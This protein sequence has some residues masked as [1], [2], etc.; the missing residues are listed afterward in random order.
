MKVGR[1]SFPGGKATG[2]PIKL[3]DI[4][5]VADTP[6]FGPGEDVAADYINSQLGGINGHPVQIVHCDEKL[7]PSVAATCTQQFIQAG[8]VGVIGYPLVWDS[9]QLPAI[10]R[11]G[12]PDL[13]IAAS[14]PEALACG[15]CHT[16]GG[17]YPSSIG[18]AVPY[19]KQIGAKSMFIIT[20]QVPGCVNAGKFAAKLATA[21]GIKY[22]G[23][24]SHPTAAPDVVTGVRKA[25][26]T[27]PDVILLIDD[28]TSSAREVVAAVQGGF[29]GKIL[30]NQNSGAPGV[31]QSMGSA[32]SHF[33]FSAATLSYQD[34]ANPE[35]KAYQEAMKTYHGS[36]EDWVSLEGFSNVMT[37]AA[38][39]EHITGTITAAS[40]NHYYN[41]TPIIPM[42]AGYALV[43]TNKPPS[44]TGFTS[45]YDSFARWFTVGGGKYIDA[46]KWYSPWFT[47]NNSLGAVE[48]A[49]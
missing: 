9:V 33:A 45:Y 36:N 38:A 32:A 26:A 20:C 13:T 7:S 43:R 1:F 37:V 40:V 35:V 34:A 4:E 25:L 8:V 31:I 29:K 42:W 12:I 17:S 10:E 30:S 27:H 5:S 46:G 14:A 24:A 18:A 6:E 49:G 21:N 39:L 48:S 44:S 22:L 3:G 16:L 11:A 2:S 47:A 28:P 15:V 19:S 23:S 41:V